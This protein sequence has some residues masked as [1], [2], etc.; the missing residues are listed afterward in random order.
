MTVDE[1]IKQLKAISDLGHGETEVTMWCI[2]H[3]GW[4]AMSNFSYTVRD[5]KSC[6]H[7]RKV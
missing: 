5:N 2:E 1:L 4:H 7:D 3:D 6:K